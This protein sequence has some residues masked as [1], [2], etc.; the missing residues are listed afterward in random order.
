MLRH[1]LVPI[2]FG[3][4]LLATGFVVPA[5]ASASP[6][7]IIGTWSVTWNSV[8]GTQQ[9]RLIDIT[10]TSATIG[11]QPGFIGTFSY[12]SPE[13]HCADYAWKPGDSSQPP[14]VI[15]AQDGDHYSGKAMLQV[16]S[17]VTYSL[18]TGEYLSG[19]SCWVDL[20]EPATWVVNGDEAAV[21]LTCTYNTNSCTPGSTLTTKWTRGSGGTATKESIRV[22]VNEVVTSTLV[23]HK[24]YVACKKNCKT[25]AKRLWHAAVYGR[26][27]I[28][29][30][31]HTWPELFGRTANAMFDHW[32]KAGAAAVRQWSTSNASQRS[33]YSKIASKEVGLTQQYWGRLQE[34]LK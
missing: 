17:D 2:I 3:L 32:V 23:P 31:S 26:D 12:L 4:A 24:A 11:G 30:E 9:G 10:V 25:K 16:S 29:T 15:A 28:K 1:R 20:L 6:A 27:R 21:V 19:N 5:P 34:L 7:S 18:Q 14:W 13:F 8:T 22:T 33:Y